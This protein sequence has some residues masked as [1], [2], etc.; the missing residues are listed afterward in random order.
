VE[1]GKDEEDEDE[2]DEDEEDAEDGEEEDDDEDW[3][4]WSWGA[5]E[6]GST[7]KRRRLRWQ[8]KGRKLAG[9]DQS[10]K[11]RVGEVA[12]GRHA[13]GAGA[14]SSSG[15]SSGGVHEPVGRAPAPKSRAFLI[16]NLWRGPSID[17][18][19]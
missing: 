12:D 9:L 19:L 2:E 5:V 11:S 18:R 6:R 3:G 16:E 17:S 1:E 15:R 7:A 4:E 14:G 8:A 13:G 10:A